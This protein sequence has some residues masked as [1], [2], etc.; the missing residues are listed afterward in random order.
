[1]ARRDKDLAD[2]LVKIAA[3]LKI[4]GARIER[5]GRHPCLVGEFEGRSLRY[6]FPGSTGSSRTH[7]N[8]V[9][10]FRNYIRSGWPNAATAFGTADAPRVRRAP[11]ARSPF[12]ST[13]AD[14]VRREKAGERP[15]HWHG[16]LEALRARLSAD[17]DSPACARGP[18][19]E[20]GA[21]RPPAFH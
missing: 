10:Q 20:A 1:M 19:T 9:S 7:K 5:G 21:D 18:D 2:A 16:P 11:R 6:A 14:I 3:Q 13:L 4:D 12:S 8:T 15:D 17:C